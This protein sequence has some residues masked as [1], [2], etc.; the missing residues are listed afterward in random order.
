V[1]CDELE[2]RFYAKPDHNGP[3]NFNQAYHLVPTMYSS[4]SAEIDASRGSVLGIMDFRYA[5]YA[6]GDTCTWLI[7]LQ[8]V[9]SRHSL[10][11]IEI[12]LVTLPWIPSSP[13]QRHIG[14]HNYAQIIDGLLP[15]FGCCT[16]IRSV[17]IFEH[18]RKQLHRV[19]AALLARTPSWPSLMSHLQKD[20]DY[21][22]H[23]QINAFFAER[24]WIPKLSP[25]LGFARE[26]EHF[27]QQMC[28]GRVPIVVNIRQSAL[29]KVPAAV[30][31]DSPADV[32][33]RFFERAER[34]WPKALFILAGGF[35]EWERRFARR[36]NVIIPRLFGLGLGHELTLLLGGTPFIGTSSGF[37]AAATFSDT[38][39]VIT[40]FE[41]RAANF[42]GI[43]VGAERYPFG[44]ER[45]WLSWEIET[46]ELLSD[47]FDRLW[48]SLCFQ[49]MARPASHV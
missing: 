6:L 26:T 36:P 32:W 39:Y 28:N 33:F 19:L 13:L 16:A 45:Q 25:P 11:D 44:T 24:G 48:K 40:N 15:A 37:S 21:I 30:N 8:I 46:D 2:I 31:R 35:S 49:E 4:L 3:R 1:G 42:L 34:H 27:K 7:N 10:S 12:M 43:P 22:S 38:P 5:P 41:H 17:R 14:R 29:T 47:L 9:A 18:N 23:K 20:L